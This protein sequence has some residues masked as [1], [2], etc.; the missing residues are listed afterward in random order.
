[1]QSKNGKGFAL[2]VLAPPLSAQV[3]NEDERKGRGE[4][5]GA[6][7]VSPRRPRGSPPLDVDGMGCDGGKGWWDGL[8]GWGGGGGG[9][10]ERGGGGRDGYKG[11]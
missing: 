10:V 2:S 11:G 5:A 4:V 3:R 8:M 9:W 6:A 7:R 1:M